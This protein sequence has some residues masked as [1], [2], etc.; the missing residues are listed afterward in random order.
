MGAF[1]WHKVICVAV[2][3]SLL[4][5]SFVFRPF[6]NHIEVHRR[7]CLSSKG[8]CF[9]ANPTVVMS[10]D[11]LSTFIDRWLNASKDAVIH[12]KVQNR[13]TQMKPRIIQLLEEQ[14]WKEVNPDALKYIGYEDDGDVCFYFPDCKTFPEATTDPHYLLKVPQ[15]CRSQA[16]VKQIKATIDNEA[17]T[18]FVNRSY[19]SGV[20]ICAGNQCTYTVSNKQKI[21]RCKDHPT[22]SLVSSGPCCC[23]MVYIYPEDPQADGR[24]WFMVLNSLNNSQMHNHLPPSEWKISPKVLNDISNVVT[25]NS[26]LTPKEIQKGLGMDYSPMEKSIAAAN[27]DRLRA[28]V[29]K[30]KKD[31]YKVDN[32]KI[33]PFKIVA[34]FPSI[35]EKIDRNNMQEALEADV[36]DKMV[37][38]YQLDGDNAYSFTRDRR[39]AYFQSPFQANHWSKASALFVDI[40]HTSN[41]H[42]PYL[43]NIVCLNDVTNKYIACGRA[44]MNRQ[45]GYSIG[46]A[47]ATL[48]ANVKEYVST[49]SITA[50]HKEILLDFDDAEASGFRE[51]FGAEITN[52]FRG[53]YVH[54]I[55]SSM[56]V[57]KQVN[58]SQSSIGYQI[59]MSI[60]KL[61]PVKMK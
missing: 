2:H 36:I 27:I 44:L 31:V 40:D 8:E 55:R 12:K 22:S 5:I 25:R 60:V 57:A 32:D 45:D 50:A 29:N 42:F 24:R 39:F 23:H 33:N 61:I 16:T 19:C 52:L 30:S 4:E 26:Q 7:L 38:K 41:H 11:P 18:L 9:L 6:D 15:L 20:K 21:N 51:A 46:K 10:L 54:F 1:A 17:M 56:R 48:V 3:L 58:P 53:C 34:S 47:L 43:L 28:V 59:F 14:R 49:Y 37:G 35:K 13:G